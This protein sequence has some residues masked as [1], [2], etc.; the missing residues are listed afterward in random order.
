VENVSTAAQNVSTAAQHDDIEVFA[1]RQLSIMA[2]QNARRAEFSIA[3]PQPH[4]ITTAQ[5]QPRMM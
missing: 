1:E 2:A 5:L 4:N 3:S